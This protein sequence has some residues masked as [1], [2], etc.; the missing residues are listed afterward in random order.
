MADIDWEAQ[1]LQNLRSA[2]EPK[3]GDLWTE[4]LSYSFKVVGISDVTVTIAPVRGGWETMTR[5]DFS[6][7]VRYSAMADKTWCDV[8]PWCFRRQPVYAGAAV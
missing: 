2:D 4:R 8:L 7:Y 3:V 6:K 1:R 5:A